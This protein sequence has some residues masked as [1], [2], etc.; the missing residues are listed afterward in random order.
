MRHY[1]GDVHEMIKL[2]KKQ[3]NIWTILKRV[4]S[5][6]TWLK[7]IWNVIIQPADAIIEST[8]ESGCIQAIAWCAT[9]TLIQSQSLMLLQIDLHDETFD[10]WV[11]SKAE[12]EDSNGW[13]LSAFWGGIS[14]LRG[15]S[16]SCISL[17]HEKSAVL[18]PSSHI[19][20]ISPLRCLAHS[21][22]PF[23]WSQHKNPNEWT[24]LMP[25]P[26][27]RNWL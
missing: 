3:S 2:Q 18:I 13:S 6:I 21:L 26:H 25:E 22:M 24:P 15:Y 27:H 20:C 4:M 17:K 23:P 10:L 5:Q 7:P 19:Q 12:M 9:I 11:S 14:V 8:Y 16:F 1:I